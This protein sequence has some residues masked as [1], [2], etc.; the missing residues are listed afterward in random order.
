MRVIIAGSRGINDYQIVLDAI[1]ESPFVI[2]TVISGGANG[3]DK[4]GEKW[5]KATKRNLEVFHAN[6]ALY[7]QAAGAIRNRQM[8][9]HADALIAVW[10]GVSPGTANMIDE[11]RKRGLKVYVHSIG[12]LDDFMK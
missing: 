4:L 1:Y 12:G 2:R 6:W 9:E 10:D 7:K 11:A 5:A 8:A 3:V